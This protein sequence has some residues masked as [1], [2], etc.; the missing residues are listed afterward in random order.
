MPYMNYCI[1]TG[2]SLLRIFFQIQTC[3]PSLEPQWH[4]LGRNKSNVPKSKHSTLARTTPRAKNIWGCLSLLEPPICETNPE[5]QEQAL[6]SQTSIPMN[7]HIPIFPAFSHELSPELLEN[8][9][10]FEVTVLRDE[11]ARNRPAAVGAPRLWV[12]EWGAKWCQW[13]NSC[14]FSCQ[15]N[16]GNPK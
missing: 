13:G 1:G 10:S 6:R 12:K 3:F 9:A 4:S 7:F 2:C 14:R 5:D 11:F 16:R 15:T 8:S